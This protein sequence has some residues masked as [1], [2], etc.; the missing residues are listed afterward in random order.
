MGRLL[1]LGLTIRDCS[2]AAAI[3]CFTTSWLDFVMFIPSAVSTGSTSSVDLCPAM[4]TSQ[5]ALGARVAGRTS[6]MYTCIRSETRT[7]DRHTC[8]V[9]VCSVTTNSRTCSNA[10]L[11]ISFLLFVYVPPCAVLSLLWLSST[12]TSD[13]VFSRLCRSPR[14]SVNQQTESSAVLHIYALSFE[15]GSVRGCYD[16]HQTGPCRLLHLLR[17]SGRPLH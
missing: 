17:V 5:R 15:L 3:F 12:A 2:D 8:F 14:P 1:F 4:R 7:E 9:Y 6:E 16:R 10:V 11:H 13:S